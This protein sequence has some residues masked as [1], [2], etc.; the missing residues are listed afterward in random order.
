[1][2]L[3]AGRALGAIG[4][5]LVSPTLRGRGAGQQIMDAADA[6]LERYAALRGWRVEAHI[7]ESEA[8]AAR[9]WSRQGY[10]W[11]EGMRFWQPPLAY[12]PDGE[13]ALPHIPLFL[14]IRHPQHPQQIPA[15][16][17]EEYTR[18]L[19]AQWY[20]D[21]LPKQVPGAAACERARRWFDHTILTPTIASIAHDPVAMKDLSGW[22][23]AEAE[24]C[25]RG[26]ADP[27]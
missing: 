10:R 19:L 14:M 16:L 11:P 27:R 2:P 8:G 7:L 15:A 24:A 6:A 12:T 13:P 4:H 1:M 18:A 25:L 20:R 26:L 21:E 5:A 22:R 17:V 23:L 9:F 3:S